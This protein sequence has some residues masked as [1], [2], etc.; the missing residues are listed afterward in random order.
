MLNIKYPA[1]YC[2]FPSAINPHSEATY[3]HSLEW[4]RSFNLVTD[5]SVYQRWRDLDLSGWA[6]YCCPQVSLEALKIISDCTVY[7]FLLD[8]ECE[9]AGASKQLEWLAAKQTRLIDILKGAELTDSDTLFAHALQNI[10]QRLLQFGTSEWMLGFTEEI[11][12]HLK[13]VLWEALNNSQ[14]IT[15][16]LATYRQ[17]RPLTCGLIPFFR[18]TLF[19]ERIDLP[20]EIIKHTL[21]NQMEEVA[22]LTIGWAN[23]I[24]SLEKEI[25]SGQSDNLVQI[26]Q[27]EYQIPLHEAIKRAASLHDT[28]VRTF[29]EL[30]AQLPSF[31]AE[32]DANL[33]R[34][35]L[36]L[37]SW[38]RGN[39]DWSLK[40]RRYRI[41]QAA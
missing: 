18:L 19:A 26:L 36:G 39:I 20:T 41:N 40:T 5:E 21:V 27:H 32:I 7:L 30:S 14:G 29:I 37:H 17:I 33:Q 1:L 23:D 15:P 6:V 4:V 12:R 3:Q 28:E 31:G 25:M 16:D 34:Y 24:L 9:S 2:P 22:S 35:I 13:G 11:E 10:R 8:D 38:M